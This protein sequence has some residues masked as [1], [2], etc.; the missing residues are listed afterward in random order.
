VIRQTKRS[1]E[2]FRL[3]RYTRQDY[4]LDHPHAPAPQADRDG[5]PRD[6]DDDD[7]GPPP[8]MLRDRLG[9]RRS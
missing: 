1:R 9:P 4:R 7:D 6:D 3:G 8:P 2:R 5:R